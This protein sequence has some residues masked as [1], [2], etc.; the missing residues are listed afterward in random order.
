MKSLKN[1]LLALYLKYD[2]DFNT[3]STIALYE[4]IVKILYFSNKPVSI[5]ELKSKV[6]S[7]IGGELDPQSYHSIACRVLRS[8]AHMSHDK[9]QL[10]ADKRNEINSTID[11]SVMLHHR[12]LDTYFSGTDIN[13]EDRMLW[14]QEI[15][16][17]FFD[18][19][20]FQWIHNTTT[21]TQRSANFQQLD[22]IAEA[23][24]REFNFEDKDKSWL[25]T[26]FKKFVYESNPDADKLFAQYGLSSFSARLINAKNFANKINIE[27]FKDATF[28]LDTN[29]LMILD[30]ESHTLNRSIAKLES[31]LAS[32]NI[33]LNYLYT[34][35]E[36]YRGAMGGKRGELKHV[37]EEYNDALLRQSD[38]PFIKTAIHRQCRTTEDINRMF[39]G[40]ESVPSKFSS[41]IDID[42]IDNE[43]VD[44]AVQQG[45][46]DTKIKDII[47]TIYKSY[48]GYDKREPALLHDAGIIAATQYLR[49]TGKYIILTNDN[50]LKRYSIENPIRDEIGIAIGLDVLISLLVVSGGGTNMDPT[51][52]APLFKNIVRMS[53]HP[54]QDA[55]RVEDLSFILGVN[56]E[57]Q[58]MPNDKVV[59]LAK[60][61]N[62][63]MCAGVPSHDIALYLRREIEAERLQQISQQQNDN[64]EKDIL[65]QEV[66]DVREELSSVRQTNSIEKDSME[67]TIIWQWRIIYMFLVILLCICEYFII[68]NEPTMTK[69]LSELSTFILLILG[70]IPIQ[71]VLLKHVVRDKK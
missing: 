34:T 4:L 2:T 44:R 1:N 30:L 20:N 51:D 52:F 62:Q 21:K 48:K 16:V 49:K 54:S 46:E 22:E 47:N 7:I 36:E 9:Y 63:Q 19:Y 28:I 61:V 32:L 8:C 31:I 50:I 68:K 3:I 42:L 33:K 24:F 38:C 23:S 29:I 35:Q 17:L 56:L 70:Y 13:V 59:A 11:E 18:A 64:R 55:F 66:K 43:D 57:I 37:F 45:R 10:N 15:M 12:V 39:D 65:K 27:Q 26:Q 5:K 71:K 40:L 60:S 25:C 58:K 14:F 53:L 6:E 69:I 41:L 67:R